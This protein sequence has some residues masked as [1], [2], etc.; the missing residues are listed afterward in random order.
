MAGLRGV[1]STL[2]PTDFR[3]SQSLRLHWFLPTTGDGREIV[4]AFIGS[5]GRS[6]ESA[7]RQPTLAYLTQIATAAEQLG[8][9]SVLTPT[10]TWCE[11][12]WIATAALIGATERLRF[13]VA[14][15]PSAMTP[16]AVAQLSSTFQRMSGGRLALNVVTGGDPDDL[17]RFGDWLPHDT[18]YERTAEFL[19][20]LRGAWSGTPFDFAGEHY[21]V[22]GATVA[23]AP[24]PVPEIYFGG[25]SPAAAAVSGRQADVHLVWAEPLE[26]TAAQLDLVRAQAAKAGRTVE[27]GLRVHVISRDTSELAWAEA[28]R[29]LAGVDPAAVQAAQ[30]RFARHDSHGQH[31]MSALAAA[32]PP[33]ARLSTSADTLTSTD[34]LTLAPA[35]ARHLEVAPNLWAGFGLLRP[36]AGTALVGSHQEVAERLADY[37]DLGIRHVI[38]SGQPHLEEA[39]TVAEN[40]VPRLRELGLL[41][42]APG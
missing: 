6:A 21:R 18:R 36:R 30:Q 14:V 2:L 19:S 22:A 17:H 13:I 40:V 42:T 28:D 32:N 31:R 1:D 25:A 4:G 26:G 5:R 29:M 27:F 35:G 11:D 24:D 16:T 3:A 20:V 8:F 23:E 39:Y 41:P 38:A 37:H 15:R 9:E 33:T 10:G 12:P 34:T 7:T